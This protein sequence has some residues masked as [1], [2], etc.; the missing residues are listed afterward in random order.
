MVLHQ[1]HNIFSGFVQK[2]AQE[3][4]HGLQLNQLQFG[5]RQDRR[6]RLAD[7]QV[8]QVQLEKWDLLVQ[9][10]SLVQLALQAL[11]QVLFQDP[12][13]QPV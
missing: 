11:F 5:G 3:M 9:S 13:V 8:Q 7:H 4:V 12:P 2:L 6:V 1:L 10:A